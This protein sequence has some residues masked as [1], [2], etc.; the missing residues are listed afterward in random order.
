MA[1]ATCFGDTSMPSL[2][3]AC[4]RFLQ[5]AA[6]LFELAPSLSKSRVSQRSKVT[7]LMDDLPAFKMTNLLH[8]SMTVTGNYLFQFSGTFSAFSG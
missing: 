5:R 3:N 7:A 2:F 8:S 4:T 1:E 6:V